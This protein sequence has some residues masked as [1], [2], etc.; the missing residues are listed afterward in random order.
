[1]L[2]LATSIA[3]ISLIIG[4]MVGRWTAPN[5][6]FATHGRTPELHSLEAF[7]KATIKLAT[8]NLEWFPDGTSARDIVAGVRMERTEGVKSTLEKISPDI[9]CVQ[10][11]K[12]PAVFTRMAGDLGYQTQLLSS[13]RGVQEI[14]IVSRLPATLVGAADFRAR[15]DGDNIT[16]PR[17]FVYGLFRLKS[18]NLLV[19]SVHLKSNVGG[20]PTTAPVRMESARQLLEHIELM[21]GRRIDPTMPL[22]VVLAGDFNTDP[23][24]TTFEVDRTLEIL[25]ARGFQSTFE[26]LDRNEVITWHSDGRYPSAT[27]DHILTPDVDD[28]AVVYPSTRN[29]SDHLPVTLEL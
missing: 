7:P 29:L 10:E 20:I 1:M 5:G 26:G 12:D 27:F 22:K 16:P 3:A 13:F 21:R 8:W 28:K 9:L 25:Q 4:F 18:L 2:K 19:Y 23:Y 17:G 15:L 24:Q 11:I 6:S 14:G